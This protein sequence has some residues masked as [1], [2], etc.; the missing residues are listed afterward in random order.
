MK[1]IGVWE[2]D[3]AKVFLRS[4]TYATLCMAIVK[5]VLNKSMWIFLFCFA[6]ANS[7]DTCFDI[8]LMYTH[9][10]AQTNNQRLKKLQPLK[11]QSFNTPE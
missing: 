6:A 7:S 2:W 4:V 1:A 10:I 5:C 8:Q 11:Q 9:F 3:E